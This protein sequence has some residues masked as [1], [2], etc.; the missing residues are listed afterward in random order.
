MSEIVPSHAMAPLK[1][2][3]AQFQAGSLSLDR[4]ADLVERFSRES[5]DASDEIRSILDHAVRS[6]ALSQ[7]VYRDLV[8]RLD[9]AT[10][11]VRTSFTAPNI[12][13]ETGPASGAAVSFEEGATRVEETI[14]MTSLK[15][16]VFAD[17]PSG[18]VVPPGDVTR[19][20]SVPRTAQTATTG[21]LSTPPPGPTEQS[22]QVGDILK[23]RFVLEQVLGAGG[24]GVVFKALDLRKK[25][26][27]DR[28]PYVALK[29]LNQ[30]FRDNPVSLIALQRETKRAQTLSHP[31]I[32][33]V[34]D[35]DRDGSHVYMSME[36]LDQR[37]LSQFIKEL[38]EGGLPFK[39]AWPIIF[40]MG[41]ALA[42]AH[43]KGIVH[44]DFKPSN[45][46][47]D[48]HYDVKVLDFGIACAIG[49]SDKDH[50]EATLFDPRALGALTPAY[51]S[52]EMFEDEEPDPRDD[53]Y[54]LACV[55]YEL[56]T[57]KH[58][59]GRLTAQQAL[60]LN[61]QPK[62]VPGLTRRQWHGLQRG[63]A[64]KRTDRTPSV[65][66]FLR[67][68]QKRSVVFYGG[69]VAGLVLVAVT[70]TNVY[71]NLNAPSEPPKAP[72]MLTAEQQA[73]IKDLLELAEIHFDVGYLTAPPGSNALW[74]YREVLK[75]DPYN[76]A[77]IRGLQKIADALEQAAW[78]YY[79]QG[80]RIESMKKVNEGLEA[81][82]KHPGL[83]KL[84]QKL[85]G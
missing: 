36:Y 40:G 27:N 80:N 3:L 41:S 68:L 22:L 54:A 60:E 67:E 10:R 70:A 82:P 25:E 16:V 56:L 57:G 31:N 39:K 9:D 78:E 66:E 26:A 29:V 45:V 47:I 83:L 2:A 51:A 55:T 35:F 72:V 81:N 33:N 21:G 30:A 8:A 76:E 58:P 52:L 7:A 12:R 14:A 53:I 85:Q 73:K 48:E 62:A 71:L 61:L 74:A 19:P 34:Y 32:I 38:P 43:K 64:L 42:Y 79:E 59:F 75:I 77:A 13:S 63:L 37:T 28:D 23:D 11:V 49:R 18:A 15:T 24:M 44:S 17:Q 6:G 50:E 46:F 84:K 4:L 65:E 5:P 20:P 69:W 1:A